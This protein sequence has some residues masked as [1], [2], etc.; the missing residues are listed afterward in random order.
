[1]K[2]RVINKGRTEVFRYKNQAL[3]S[4]CMVATLIADAVNTVPSG[5][6]PENVRVKATLRQDGNK[7]EVFNATLDALHLASVLNT[8]E[9]EEQHSIKDTGLADGVVI[10]R[11]DGSTAG[12]NAFCGVIKLPTGIILKG[13]D[14]LEIEVKTGS[15]CFHA[16]CDSASYWNLYVPESVT[17]QIG[18]PRIQV[19]PIKDDVQNFEESLGDNI[20]KVVLISVDKKTIDSTPFESVRFESDRLDLNVDIKDLYVMKLTHDGDNGTAQVLE[21]VS[22]RDYDSVS[23]G[24]DLNTAN[25]TNNKCYMVV[26]AVNPSAGI[27]MRQIERTSKHKNAFVSKLTK[28]MKTFIKK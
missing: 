5:C 16:D 19:M 10:V 11:E 1:M 27:M 4:I 9:V 23:V 15:D 8:T 20:K 18:T 21:V 24:V 14:E 13:S 3:D 6:Y 7:S 17:E 12:E 25:V 28:G 2:K 22:G 26:S